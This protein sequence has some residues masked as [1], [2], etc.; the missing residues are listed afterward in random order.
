MQRTLTAVLAG[1]LAAIPAAGVGAQ[2]VYY[3]Q[4]NAGTINQAIADARN[5]FLGALG[6]VSTESFETIAVGTRAPIAL[7]FAGA[8]TATLTGTGA[9]AG[10][11]SAGA[12]A[13]EGSRYYLV[14]TSTGNEFTINFSNAIAAFGFFGT[15]LGD[16]GSNLFLRFTRADG[17]TFQT[18]VPF[19]AA[20]PLASGN[21]LFYGFIDTSNPFTAVQFVSTGS[22]DVFGFDEMTIGTSGQVVNPPNVIPEPA[23]VALLGG[24]LALAGAFARR[25][26]A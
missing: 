5:G 9:V 16:A 19:N 26:T 15:D 17:T 12:F 25:R 18:Q 13:T 22:G 3:G 14:T 21:R 4:N 2:T 23:T 11:P 8:G 1:F 24:G 20:T 10:A 7:G 6:G